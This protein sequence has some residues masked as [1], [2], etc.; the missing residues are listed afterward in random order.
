L[1]AGALHFVSAASWRLPIETGY[2]PR[3]RQYAQ[4]IPARRQR[5][6]LTVLVSSSAPAVIVR[7]IAPPEPRWAL[8]HIAAPVVRWLFYRAVRGDVRDDHRPERVSASS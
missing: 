5:T 2:E 8:E 7:E 1:R 6:V 4:A 3:N